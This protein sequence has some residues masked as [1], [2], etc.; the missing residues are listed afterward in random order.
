MGK[1]LATPEIEIDARNQFIYIKKKRETYLNQQKN[2]NRRNVNQSVIHDKQWVD[3][4]V[5][6][7]LNLEFGD[8]A[9]KFKTIWQNENKIRIKIEM[10]IVSEMTIHI[11]V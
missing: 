5:V 2:K 7:F 6:E 9:I 10:W 4:K 3:T 1:F 8:T 11:R